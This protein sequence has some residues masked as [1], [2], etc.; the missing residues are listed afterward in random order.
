LW[1]AAK[2]GGYKDLNGNGKPDPG[3]WDTLKPGSPDNYFEVANL[4]ELP[5]KLGAAF[6]RISRSGDAITAT[7]DSVTS[8]LGGGLA[9]QTS[10][11]PEFIHSMDEGIVA[12]KQ[13]K[14]KW[15][16]NVYSLFLDQWGHLRED[17]NY[18]G[19]LDVITKIPGEEGS[20]DLVVRFENQADSVKSKITLWADEKGTNVL[21]P[22]NRV[23]DNMYGLRSVWDTSQNLAEMADPENSRTLYAYTGA[24]PDVYAGFASAVPLSGYLFNQTNKDSLLPYLVQGYTL[25]APRSWGTCDLVTSNS[26]GPDKAAC[27]QI[28][29]SAVGKPPHSATT[30]S[31]EITTSL[32]AGQVVV[33]AS[34]SGLKMRVGRTTAV[35]IVNAINNFVYDIN[36][37]SLIRASLN[38][39]DDGTWTPSDTYTATLPNPNNPPDRNEIA[40]SLIRFVTGVEIPGWR[41]RKACS[42]WENTPTTKITWRMGDVIN[43]KPTIVGEPV[44]G[45]DLIYGD[46]SYSQFKK[47][48][49]SDGGTLG[50]R[51]VTY[52]GSNDGILHAVNL[53]YYGSLEDGTIGYA[54]TSFFGNPSTAHD[55][56][57]EIWG[58]IPTSVLPH[59]SWMTDPAYSHSYYVDLEP[60]I[61]DIRNTSSSTYSLA[62]GSWTPG[63]WKTI[64]VM[65]LRLGGRSIELDYPSAPTRFLY[66]EYFAL[67]ITNPEVPPTLLWRFSHPN[68]GLP[69]N[70][71]AVVSSL[72]GWHIVI[73]SG[74]TSDVE[75]QIT[76]GG[77]TTTVMAPI[78]NGQIAYEGYSNQT[79]RLFVLNAYTGALQRELGGETNEGV[80]G[81]NVL[82]NSFFN[83]S[84]V[85]AAVGPG[86]DKLILRGE[87]V[88]EIEYW[89]NNTVYFGLTQS[90]TNNILDSGAL[91]RLQMVDSYGN[92]TGVSNWKLTTFYNPDRPVT[93]AVNATFDAVGNLWVVF[94]TGKL[95]SEKDSAPACDGLATTALKNACQANHVQYLFGIKE[96]MSNG[97]LT[98]GQ[99]VETNSRKLADVSSARVFPDGTV[100][101]YN[102][103]STENYEQILTWMRGDEYLGYKRKLNTWAY[104]NPNYTTSKYEM[105]LTQPKI[106]ALPNG[107]SIMVVTTYEPSNDFC[108]PEGNSFLMLADTFTGIPAP[109]MS[110]LGFDKPTNPIKG[111]VNDEDQ[112][113]GYLDAGRGQATE[114]W[115]IKT[116]SGTDYGDNSANQVL[117]FVHRDESSEGFISGT[118]WWREVMDM[119][120]SLDPEDLEKGLLE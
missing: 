65:G 76:E 77:V 43:S 19:K 96:P 26:C 120:F 15:V 37:P 14:I 7:S 59:L 2:Y 69:I 82:E 111:G 28:H 113:T 40:T 44:G 10:Y 92:P 3:E 6:D 55:L 84:F 34:G 20:G 47:G 115:V 67:D 110:G 42:P 104:I 87:N 83:N 90:R 46:Y 1:L 61:V 29:F 100:T 97:V 73:G 35:G 24:T 23:V 56:G 49:I 81:A 91:M 50:R 22:Y 4:S 109:Y 53:G 31:I 99:V 75:R 79:A 36:A 11:V 8:V 88:G 13:T 16:G 33:V 18:N 21:T 25:G 80:S 94:G 70:K 68:M 30:L 108:S 38:P 5:E 78:D 103:A 98:Y 102:G 66:S 57:A 117:N 27:K 85:P 60:M 105:I 45:Y 39:G 119:G 51:I 112:I 52:F 116:T 86:S 107:R 17:T 9:L 64:L 58:F 54:K 63:T 114:A 93:G 41:S 48:A 32:T 89:H 106:D 74:P 72:D 12:E 95:W 101:G 62:S 118:L 71:P